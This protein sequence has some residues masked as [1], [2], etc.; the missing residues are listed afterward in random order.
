[1]FGLV[2]LGSGRAPILAEGHPRI[3]HPEHL[4]AASLFAHPLA[5]LCVD[6]SA[7]LFV[8]GR[9]GA[10]LDVVAVALAGGLGVRASRSAMR[11]QVWVC[12]YN[13]VTVLLQ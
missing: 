13:G 9:L 12:N 10:E 5:G 8:D 1:V 2:G 7:G 11:F 4:L 6:G 3:G